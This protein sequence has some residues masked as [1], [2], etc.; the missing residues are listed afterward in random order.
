[1]TLL[2]RWIPLVILPPLV[3]LATIGFDLSRISALPGWFWLGAILLEVVA[4]F[5]GS[6]AVQRRIF[7]CT[8]R[9][10]SFQRGL[11]MGTYMFLFTLLGHALQPSLAWGSALFMGLFFGAFMGLLYG[12]MMA[13]RQ[14]RRG[15][16]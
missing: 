6:Q 7:T 16:S 1:M 3:V 12:P 2:Q 4:F 13:A 10:V 14:T 5:M 11:M 8:G 15:H 9:W